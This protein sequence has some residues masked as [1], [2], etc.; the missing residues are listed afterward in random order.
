[1]FISQAIEFA[2]LYKIH[3]IPMTTLDPLYHFTNYSDFFT[4]FETNTQPWQV[5]TPIRNSEKDN[6]FNFVTELC[7][8]FNYKGYIADEMR[9]VH[10][11]V[12]D[13]NKNFHEEV[14]LCNP[15]EVLTVLLQNS[16]QL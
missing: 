2:Y 8:K 1:M 6:D 9:N 4:K 10:G 13:E 12:V 14:M 15:K 7:K 5:C 11:S 16:T 3:N